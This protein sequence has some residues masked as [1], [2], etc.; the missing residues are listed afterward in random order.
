MFYMFTGRG[1]ITVAAG[2]RFYRRF[3]IA[4]VD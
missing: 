2:A 1:R 4:I 3:A